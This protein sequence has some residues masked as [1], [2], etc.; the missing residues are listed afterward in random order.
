LLVS[1]IMA[2]LLLRIHIKLVS[3]QHH[4]EK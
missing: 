3:Q 2:I 4:K 1:T